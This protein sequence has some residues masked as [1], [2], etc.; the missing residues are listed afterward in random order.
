MQVSRRIF[1]VAWAGTALGTCL[2][3]LAEDTP[4]A[5]QATRPSRL[6][7]ATFRRSLRERGLFELLDLYDREHPATDDIGRMMRQHEALLRVRDNPKRG[8]R[9]RTEA[10]EQASQLLEKLL[11]TNP[12]HVDR[13]AW[14]AELGRDL[15]ERQSATAVEALLFRVASPKQ[16]EEIAATT[17]R[18]IRTLQQLAVDIATEWQRIGTLSPEQ[19]EQLS[20][21]NRPKELESIEAAGAY[22]MAWARLY[23]AMVL[24]PG[25]TRRAELLSQ[26]T[27]DIVNHRRWTA[28]PHE[29]T[30]L[31]MQSLVLVAIAQRLA[32]KFDLADAAS[33]QAVTIY[34]QTTDPQRRRKLDDW[35]LLAVL[36]R[37]RLLRDRGETSEALAAIGRAYEWAKKTRPDDVGAIIALA[38]LERSI[39]VSAG[40]PIANDPLLPLARAN[41]EARATIYESVG[42]LAQERGNPN[43]ADPLEKLGLV[44]VLAEDGA[45]P[46]EATKLARSLCGV[47]D[48]TFVAAEGLF[49]LA[50]CELARSHPTAAAQSLIRLAREYPSND[51]AATAADDAVR[52]AAQ[53][54][55]ATGEN[56]ARQRRASLAT[57]RATTQTTSD[58]TDTPQPFVAAR[59]TLVQAVQVLRERSPDSPRLPEATFAA[60]VAEQQL[61]HWREAASE[62]ARIP[63]S[64]DLSVE[65][66]LRRTRC[67]ARQF[68]TKPDAPSA[69]EAIQAATDVRRCL[70]SL[71]EAKRDACRAAE[72]TLLLAQI[73]AH[74]AVRQPDAALATLADFETR[75]PTCREWIGPMWRVRLTAMESLGRL[76]EANALVDRAMAAEPDRIGPVM[77]GLLTRMQERIERSRNEGDE[78]GV[79]EL[80]GEAAALAE[81]L[82]RW[83]QER[84][85]AHGPSRS[86]PAGV[87]LAR[88][89]AL[90]DADR[91]DEAC[92][93]AEGQPA[94][95]I[96]WQFVRAECLYR[97][98]SYREALP[99][100][101]RIWLSSEEDSV[102]WWRA[103]LRNLQCHTEIGTDPDEILQ[104]IRQHQYHH[105]EL[106]GPAVQREFDSLRKRNE[107]RKAGH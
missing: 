65:A 19:F 60:G 97:A 30:G 103:L 9:E 47:R 18:A 2:C 45:S 56:D 52:L 28:Q 57:S 14:R 23:R 102:L 89:K 46:D 1:W 70:E 38:V 76:K 21:V 53:A 34:S 8:A 80:A 3:A 13:F 93:L 43:P 61:E 81:K 75:Y 72:A 12:T 87:R 42:R 94:K 44:W 66:S 90:L 69:A 104:S 78:N 100:F 82:E 22:L 40:Q 96:D 49:L 31:Q 7:D 68:E 105:K 73:Q 5:T 86:L 77:I 55:A 6:D 11:A 106:G 32:G 25:N 16:R 17:E 29:K 27:D 37:I 64:H 91:T 83:G 63:S 99:I 85:S 15:V 36:E 95:D 4:T 92:R 101:H 88:A 98:K 39:A 41:A 74:P 54:V 84:S 79:R 20:A 35:A 50:R 59:E 51:R 10:C 67:L 24:P 48:D 58:R 107:R 33:Q 62:F 71:P 26:V